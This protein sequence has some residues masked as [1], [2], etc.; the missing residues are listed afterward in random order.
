MTTPSHI[1]PNFRRFNNARN[2]FFWMF[3][4][5]LVGIVGAG[6]LINSLILSGLYAP[7]PG[8]PNYALYTLA[9]WVRGICLLL[10]VPSGVV[11]LVYHIERRR[12]RRLMEANRA[13]QREQDRAEWNEG[14]Q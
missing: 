12:E 9:T 13:I 6:I 4:V 10:C 3:A 1:T 14:N 7:P 11:A 2:R 8:H 5:A